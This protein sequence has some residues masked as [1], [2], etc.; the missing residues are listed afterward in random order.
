MKTVNIRQLHERTGAL[1]DL[2]AE[3]HV[4][5][6]LRRGVPIAEMRPAESGA[7]RKSLPDRSALLSRFPKLPGDSGRFLEEERS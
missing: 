7:R 5:L 4:V 1:V 2:A 3:G 6:I